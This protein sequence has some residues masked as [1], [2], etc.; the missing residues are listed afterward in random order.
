MADDSDA[1][2]IAASLSEPA[3]FGTVFDRHAET[4]LR[5]LVRRVGPDTAEE[6]L[7]DLFRIAFEAR[8]GFDLTRANARPWLYGIGSNLLRHHRRSEG[9]RLRAMA[10]VV[11][12]PGAVEED[13]VASEVDARSL[14]SG[15]ARLVAELPEGER[16]VLLLAVFEELSYEEIATALGIPIGTVRSRLNRAR[17]RLRELLGRN[18]Q[19]E[20]VGDNP[21]CLETEP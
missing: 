7:G 16:E 6:L 17:G 1:E 5:F 2:V 12:L 13:P 15:T 3:A 9:R 14:A 20:D 11:A 21:R 10:D 18:G 4:L 19:R 8:T